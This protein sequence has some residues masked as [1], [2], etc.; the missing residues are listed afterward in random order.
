MT[1]LRKKLAVKYIS[2]TSQAHSSIADDL[3]SHKLSGVDAVAS[4]HGIRWATV[5]NFSRK[6]GFSF[7]NVGDVK[8]YMLKFK[9]TSTVKLCSLPLSNQA[10]IDNAHRCHTYD[11]I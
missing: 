11:V 9:T 10:F 5:L 1:C 7:C 8:A 2:A 4:V 3:T 6:D